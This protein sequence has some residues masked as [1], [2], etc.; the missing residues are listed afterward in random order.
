M[1]KL[2]TLSFAFIITILTFGQ[3][4]Q[5]VVLFEEFTGENCPPCAS[6]N[7]YVDA[8]AATRP[9]EV[10]LIHYLAPVPTPGILSAQVSALVNG[11]MNYYGVNSTPWGQELAYYMGCR[12][13]DRGCKYLLP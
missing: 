12:Y 1:K 10:V 3:G 13:P 5:R 9:N 7:P 4:V 11:R 2:V 8:L 6:V